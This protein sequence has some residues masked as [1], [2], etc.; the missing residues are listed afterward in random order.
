MYKRGLFIVFFWLF[1]LIGFSQLSTDFVSLD[2][3]T[4][5]FYLKKDWKNLIVYGKWGLKNDIDYYYL[6]MRLGIAYYEQKQYRKAIVHFLKAL[7]FNPKETSALEYLYYSY[8]F[9]GMTMDARALVASFPQSLKKRLHVIDNRALTGF[10]INNT[11]RWDPDY[12]NLVSVFT[13]PPELAL[14]GWQAIEKNLNYL[15]FRFEHQLGYKFSLHHGYGYLTKMRNMFVRENGS[16]TSYINDR[17]NQYQIFLSGNLSLHRSLS[18]NLTVHYLNLRPKVYES[19]SWGGGPNSSNYYSSVA[20]EHNLVG[21]LSG[22]LDLGLFTFH[23]GVGLSN[24]NNSVQFQKDF[25]LSFF[26]LANLNLY[27]IT[28][29]SHQS[30]YVQ[31]LC[32]DDHFV[33]DQTLGFKLFNPLW[34]EWYITLGEMSNFAVLDG[35]VI[36]NDLNSIQYKFGVNL[37]VPLFQK[38]I[39]FFILYQYIGAESRFFPYSGDLPDINNTLEHHIHSFTGGIKWNISKN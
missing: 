7:E 35:M 22:N 20:P 38:G 1:S 4:Y 33:W 25:V 5:E 14:D 30:N 8:L 11:Y 32:Y 37:L 34:M 15:T 36:Y 24:L 26:P 3:A 12:S 18:M 21:Y 2:K 9:S 39:E 16:T 27:S 31:S 10:T 28:K 29:I 23:G 6:R 17:F 13:L 19:L